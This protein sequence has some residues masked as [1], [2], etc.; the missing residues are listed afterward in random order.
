MLELRH[1]NIKMRAQPVFQAAQD[2]PLIFER[3]RLSDV[4]FKS[5]ETDRHFRPRGL[6]KRGRVKNPVRNDFVVLT[7]SP[8][9]L[10]VPAGAAARWAEASPA[11]RS[12]PSL[13][14]RECRPLS[15]PKN[16]TRPLRIQIPGALRWHLP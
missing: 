2:L 4:N 6:N 8:A 12:F 1:R 3:L 13:S 5:E 7:R 9:V 15:H 16:S 10:R 14:I 11:Q